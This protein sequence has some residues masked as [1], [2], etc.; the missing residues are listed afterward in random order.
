MIIHIDGGARGNPGPAG[1]GVHVAGPD[2]ATRDEI[3]GYL[4]TQTNN[5]AEYAALI[6]A[7]RYAVAAKEST[8]AIRSDSELLVKQ[9]R[10]EYRVKN[11]GLIPLYREAINLK[12]RIPD[13]SI[14]HVRREQNKLA[15]ALANQAMD[16]RSE[17]PAGVTTGL[18]VPAAAG[19]K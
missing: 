19:R 8:V 11:A 7:L 18:P 3:Y 13:F 5:V 2:G 15:D 1:F 14:Q 6:A 10:G 12:A 17:S 4:G 9:L 16:T